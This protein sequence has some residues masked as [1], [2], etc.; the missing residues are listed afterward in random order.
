MKFFYVCEHCGSQSEDETVIRSCE[1]LGNGHEYPVGTAIEFKPARANGEW[2]SGTVH[3]VE[4]RQ[5]DHKPL[6]VIRISEQTAEQ[7]GLSSNVTL[8]RPFFEDES[9]RLAS[10]LA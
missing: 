6:Y 7:L 9:M 8:I 10:K 4:F 3:E 2:V 5:S 1:A